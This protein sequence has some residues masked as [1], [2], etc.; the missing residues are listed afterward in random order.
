MKPILT[1]VLVML[2]TFR[3]TRAQTVTQPEDHISVFEGDSVQVKCNYLYTGSPELF[4]YVRYPKQGLQLLL[5]YTSRTSIKG[6]TADLNKTEASFHLKKPSA[7]EEDSAMYYCALSATVNGFT[8]E[9]EHK[10]LW[11]YSRCFTESSLP[12]HSGAFSL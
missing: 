9:K 11:G 1:S 12:G 6:F 8:K 2:F 5:K 4:W 7:Q 3:G 10:P